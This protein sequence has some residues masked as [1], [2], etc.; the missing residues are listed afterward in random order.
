VCH[1]SLSCCIES[2]EQRLLMFIAVDA[3]KEPAFPEISVMKLL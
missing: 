3:E 1:S 2:A